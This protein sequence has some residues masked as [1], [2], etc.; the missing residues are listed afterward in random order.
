MPPGTDDPDAY[1]RKFGAKSFRELPRTDIFGWSV[2]QCVKNGEDAH[3]LAERMI[4]LIV[5]EASNF[6]R[7]RKARQLAGITGV[8]EDVIWREITR[9]VDSELQA[10]E[11]E[12]AL[13]A[14]KAASQLKLNPAAVESILAAATEQVESVSKRKNG[15]DVTNTRRY[16]DCI[17]EKLSQDATKLDT[18]DLSVSAD[19][20]CFRARSYDLE[21]RS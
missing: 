9:S 1:I 5:N 8:P 21:L 7:L 15:Y 13:I 17:L 20:Q 14:Q 19:F 3:S 16:F 6:V 12:K 11:E 2:A 4:P 18:R 10:I